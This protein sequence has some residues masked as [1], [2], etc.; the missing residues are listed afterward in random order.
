MTYPNL[1]AMNK[2][3]IAAYAAEHLSAEIDTKQTK[4]AM[5]AEVEALIQQPDPDATEQTA[6]SPSNE[7]DS[8]QE[9]AIEAP[10]P[11]PVVPA[12]K[13]S[14]FSLMI[15]SAPYSDILPLR[16]NGKKHDLPIGKWI[17]D[18]DRALIPALDDA[19]VDYITMEQ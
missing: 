5:I 11:G 12:D 2:A 19:R 6:A 10:E 16:V 15:R 9:G 14:V 18:F 13:A 4:D 7:S 1:S 17:D 3:Q 8:E